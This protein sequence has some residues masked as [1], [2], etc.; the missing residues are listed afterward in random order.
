[1]R[2]LH[3]PQSQEFR[4][5]HVFLPRPWGCEHKGNRG[6]Q[7]LSAGSQLLRGRGRKQGQSASI[8][9]SPWLTTQKSCFLSG[10]I[11]VQQR[12]REGLPWWLSGKEPSFKQ[13]TQEMQVWS[14]GQEDPLEEEMA[15][16]FSILAWEILWRE[17]PGGIQVHGVTNSRI[18][19]SV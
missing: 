15:S 1:M 5:L 2:S 9:F 19:L 18:W 17:E 12:G 3:P 14:L 4:I 10:E 8:R 6:R 11:R 16:H 13:E 7:R